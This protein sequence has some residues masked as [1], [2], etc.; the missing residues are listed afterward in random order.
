MPVA[1]FVIGGGDV[2]ERG[3]IE[4]PLIAV[5]AGRAVGASNTGGVPSSCFAAARAAESTYA[6][7]SF[8]AMYIRPISRES[9]ETPSRKVRLK[10]VA[11]RIYPRFRLRTE[12]AWILPIREV[13]VIVDDRL[14][15][16][17]E[18]RGGPAKYAV[19]RL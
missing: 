7:A 3:A 11:T 4:S 13:S 1:E 6:W 14:R 15:N 5:A 10:H 12:G 8:I 16:R 19:S 18:N 17:R 2:G 9:P